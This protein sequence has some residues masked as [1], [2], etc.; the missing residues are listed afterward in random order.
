MTA[1]SRAKK[2]RM[3][4]VNFITLLSSKPNKLA[5]KRQKGQQNLGFT[6]LFSLQ[7]AELVHELTQLSVGFT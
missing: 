6:V 7:K 1:H 5:P 2:E 3:A 4:E